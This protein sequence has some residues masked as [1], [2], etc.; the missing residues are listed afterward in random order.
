MTDNPRNIYEQ[1][2]FIN[3][4]QSAFQ[5]DGNEKAIYAVCRVLYADPNYHIFLPNQLLVYF[6]LFHFRGLLLDVIFVGVENALVL[7]L[8]L[9]PGLQGLRVGDIQRLDE[10]RL[11]LLAA[12]GA[13]SA[14]FGFFGIQGIL[15]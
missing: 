7:Q 9:D 14:C 13:T 2:D 4:T 1:M 5:N 3:L 12:V 8:L 15:N 6:V 11:G 10:L